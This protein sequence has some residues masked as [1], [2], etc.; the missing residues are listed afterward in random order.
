MQNDLLK[1]PGKIWGGSAKK[2]EFLNEI[3][4]IWPLASGLASA[5][6]AKRKQFIKLGSL[7]LSESQSCICVPEELGRSVH[8]HLF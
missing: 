6:R 2:Y 3:S 7:A 5:G 1:N 8:L 4:K